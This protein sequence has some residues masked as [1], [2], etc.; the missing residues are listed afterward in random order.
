MCFILKRFYPIL[1]LLSNLSRRG[2][3]KGCRNLSDKR[4]LKLHYSRCAPINKI[5]YLVKCQDEAWCTS[6]LRLQITHVTKWRQKSVRFF[7]SI[8][9]TLT[10]RLDFSHLSS[11][12][13]IVKDTAFEEH[14]TQVAWKQICNSQ[15]YNVCEW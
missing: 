10:F 1:L 12:S 8:A 2:G 6:F 9:S 15:L 3:V 13:P 5:F 14:F 11:V 4:F 7:V